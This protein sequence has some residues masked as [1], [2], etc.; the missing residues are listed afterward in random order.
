MPT[1]TSS[2]ATCCRTTAPPTSPWRRSATCPT[3][4]NC[5]AD[6]TFTTSSPSDLEA[7]APCVDGKPGEG[8]GG[9]WTAN[10]LDVAS[11]PTEVATRPSAVPYEQAEL[12]PLE[13]QENMPD[14]ATAPAAPATDMPRAVDVDAIGVPDAPTGTETS[15]AADGQWVEPRTPAPTAGHGAGDDRKGDTLSR[16]AI[17]V[18]AGAPWWPWPPVA[19]VVTRPAPT[20]A[21][22]PITS[23]SGHRAASGSSSSRVRGRT[24]ASTTRS[25]TPGWTGMS[26]RHEFFGNTTTDADS[27]Y[28]SLSVGDTTCAQK[29]DRAAY[30]VP[31]LLDADGEVMPPARF[32]GLLPGRPRRRPDD[33]AAVPARA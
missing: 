24:P 21:P 27:T 3:L 32:G 31:S 22:R 6:N 25:C 11:W 9:D 33:R 29:L 18:A 17:A 15:A 13:P 1:T 19:A 20:W 30:W 12:P 28:E 2:R 7:L 16:R 14:A 8:S 26:H 23:S 5:F 4:E 10:P